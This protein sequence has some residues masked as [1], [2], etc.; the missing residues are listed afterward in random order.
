MVAR[1][2]AKTQPQ[3]LQDYHVFLGVLVD[4]SVHHIALMD[5][6]TPPSAPIYSLSKLE[7]VGLRE[8]SD[9][10]LNNQFI[11]PS[12]SSTGPPV[13]RQGEGRLSPP[14]CR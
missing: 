5:H 12:Q 13:L 10:N 6:T 3:A 2:Y 4:E 14:R 1:E 11:R 7:Q 9:E 8:F